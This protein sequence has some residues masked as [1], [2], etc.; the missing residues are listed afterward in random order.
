MSSSTNVKIVVADPSAIG[1][2]GLAIVTLVASAAK[3]GLV[4]GVG[5]VIPWVIFLGAIAQ[6]IACVND[7]KHN[8]VFGATAFGGYSLFWFG[9]G[10]TWLIELGVFGPELQMASDPKSLGAFQRAYA[11]LGVQRNLRILGVFARLALQEN[12]ANYLV[13]MPR[14]WRYI[15]RNLRAPGLQGLKALID[16]EFPSPA[17]LNWTV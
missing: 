15:Q 16:A 8:N 7:L 1:L 14:V 6:M 2:L 4:E 10:M 9:V 3:F 12:K 13:H 11:V 17:N 5:L